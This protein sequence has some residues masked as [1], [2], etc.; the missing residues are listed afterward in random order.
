MVVNHYKMRGNIFSFN[1]SGMGCSAEIIVVDLARDML[2]S[3]PNNVAVVVSMEMVGFNLYTGRERSM[4]LSNCFF[5]MGCFAVMLFNRRRDH[6]RSNVYQEE[7][8]QRFKG[9][10]VSKDVIEI[11]GDAV[12]TND[13]VDLSLFGKSLS[14]VII[15]PPHHLSDL[16][17]VPF[18]LD[19]IQISC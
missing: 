2:H 1:L 11:V 4:L 3:N 12:N 19:S 18:Q 16:S 17:P 15:P 14:P 9:L 13:E 8:E 7:D 5:R 6:R 10:R